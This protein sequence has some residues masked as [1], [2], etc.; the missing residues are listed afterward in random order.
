MDVDAFLRD[1]RNSP[2]Y[3]DQIVYTR[4]IPA[5]EA[6]Y[7]D[8]PTGL[9]LRTRRMLDTMGIARLYTHQ[10]AAISNVNAGKS[11]VIATG[12]ASGK[13]LCYQVPLLET[14]AKDRDARALLLFPTKALCQDQF[15]HFSEM[16]ACAELS[17]RLC[18]VFDG[19]TPDTLRRRLRDAASVVF[20]NPDMLHA[21]IMPQHGR[22]AR[23]FGGL[24]V[25]VVDELHV[26][27]GIL[28]ANMA[29]VVRRMMRLCR[30]YGSDPAIIA[31]SA[32]IANPGELCRRL[33]DREMTVVDD[34]GSPQARK[35]FVFWNPPRIRERALRS[36]RS[37]NVEAHEI[38]ARLIARRVPVITFS[39][40]K[41]TAELIHRYA[42]ETLRSLAPQLST[43]ITPYRGGYLPRERRAIEEK[44]FSGELLG[45]STTPALELG[46]DVGSLDASIIV[47]YPGRRASFFQQAGRA[48][49]MHEN[50]LCIL[51]GL[52]TSVNQYVMGHPAYIFDTPVEQAVVDQHNPYVIMGHLRCACFELPLPERELELF[53]PHAAMVLSVLADG[54]KVR[55][56]GDLWYYASTEIPHYE[57]SL[58][59]YGGA[60][61]MI[62]DTE[63]SAVLG[64]VN[65]F[66]AQPI[67]HPG[68][69]Y[70]H[71]GET[72]RVLEL[73]MERR[74]ATVKKEQTD[75]Y[76][77]PL[78]GTDVHHIDHQ[79]R[80]KPFGTGRAYW[81]EVTTHFRTY[82]YEKIHFYEID[83]I[84]V[85]G[86]DLPRLV[87]ETMA[88]W[89]VPPEELMARVRD[90]G[91]DAHAG[92]RAMGY[93]ARML[94]PLFFTCDTLDFS[95][96]VGS[97]N[98]PWNAV[99]IY[100]RYPLGLGF[101]EKAY[102]Q[103][104]RIIPAVYDNVKSCPCDTG[105]P[106]CVGKPLRQFS[107]WN[108]ERG[109]ASIPSKQAALMILKG[110]IAD[111]SGLCAP[112]SATLAASAESRRRQLENE[113]RRR[114]ERAREPEVAHPIVPAPQVRT[115]VPAP[116]PAHA[117]AQA[118]VARRAGR[119]RAFDKELRKRIAKKLDA[120]GLPPD[121][122][123]PGIPAGMRTRHGVARPGDFAVPAE[124]NARAYDGT[125]VRTHEHTSARDEEKSRKE[126]PGAQGMESMRQQ[127]AISV[128]NALA[129]RARKMTKRKV[130]LPT[131]H[132]ALRSRSQESRN[133][134]E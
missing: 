131:D 91:L 6:R 62:Q 28:G 19:D 2:G 86:L 24:R 30:H 16:L 96:S 22:W 36:R 109:E 72:Y 111:G 85:H 54:A 51:I 64:E 75:Y 69:I 68:A 21:G 84:S 101:T 102:D 122:P 129:A 8:P 5:R 11:V 118:D 25:I 76:T 45:V 31:S 18:G 123:M 4:T 57:V 67:V 39:K 20:T 119:R 107:T 98:S 115:A 116:E 7:A 120:N 133:K 93:A 95:H 103:L 82:A 108:V 17:D 81:G 97:V 33:F 88:L 38:M 128:G 73:D 66:D 10:S 100:E 42:V 65:V 117:L 27:A 124:T 13:S 59:N 35:T 63:S 71:L 77:Q 74:I 125:S 112:D 9:T 55:R 32:T 40:A 43:S 37:A 80:D 12:T 106:C 50:T 121:T 134:F 92:L 44:L 49:R 132:L 14:L 47:G 15:G 99:F 58:R 1:I 41:M 53:G 56:I 26:Y 130:S 3:A 126:G 34:D 52:D 79:L 113:L 87:L 94:L 70:M 105:C 46:I 23:F 61:V 114:L 29:M 110:L 104:H 78:G 90:A 127:P 83:A 89:I 60:N 48:G